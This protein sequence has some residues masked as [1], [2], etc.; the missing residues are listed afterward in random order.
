MRLLFQKLFWN[1]R[2]R[3]SVGPRSLDEI[4]KNVSVLYPRPVQHIQAES[5]YLEEHVW[6]FLQWQLRLRTPAFPGT[7]FSPDCPAPQSNSY[8]VPNTIVHFLSTKEHA[9]HLRDSHVPIKHSCQS[10]LFKYS[11]WQLMHRCLCFRCHFC[12]ASSSKY[13]HRRW[14]HSSCKRNDWVMN[15]EQRSMRWT[16]LMEVGCHNWCWNSWCSWP[17]C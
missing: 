9:S 13:S 2:R 11:W 3:P 7:S 5:I 17:Y 12:C 10:Y 8:V 6:I 4:G 1:N 15:H 16:K 14:S